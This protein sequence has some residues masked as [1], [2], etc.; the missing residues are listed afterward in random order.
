MARASGADPASGDGSPRRFAELMAAARS[1]DD[2][3][4]SAL[5]G[6]CRDY[7]L[8][9]A[10][11]GLDQGL[12]AKLGASDHVQETLLAAHQNLGQ[13]RGQTPEE[14]RGW[15]RQ[16]LLNDMH[17]ARRRYF[18]TGQRDVQR[19]QSINDSVARPG[20]LVDAQLTPGSDAVVREEARLLEEALA[21]LPEN[22]RQVIRLRDW[23]ELTFP[24]VGERMGISEEAARKLWRRAI[25]KLESLLGPPED[26]SSPPEA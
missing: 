9:I 6:E 7:L 23:D 24:Q 12:Q 16:I 20:P 8:L 15:L 13:F 1:G 17:Q 2:A 25:L 3:A 19:E 4:L 5:V 14:F 26:D 21:Q 11:K 22:Y 10:N 18:G